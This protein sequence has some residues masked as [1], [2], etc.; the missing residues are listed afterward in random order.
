MPANDVVIEGTFNVNKY[1]I[2]W[3]NHDGSLIVGENLDYGTMPEYPGQDDPIKGAGDNEDGVYNFVGWTPDL[4]SV[5]G[6]AD[7]TATFTFTGWRSDANGKRYFVND[8]MQKGWLELDSGKYYLDPDTGYAAVGVVQIGED[9]PGHAFDANGVWQENVSGVF[10]DSRTED[11]YLIGSGIVEVFPGLYMTE[12]HEYYY[13][14][15]DNKAIRGEIKWVEKN[16]ADPDNVADRGMLPKWDYDF[17][18][19]GIIKH[20]DVSINGIHESDGV[21]YYYIDGIRVH[22]GMFMQDGYYY[23]ANRNGKLITDRTYWCTDNYGLMDEGSYPFDAQGRMIMPDTEKNGILEED[24]S[25][26]YYVD[27]V[28]T[29]AGLIE[30]DG[31]YYYVK[32]SGEVVH[33]QK[34]WIT[35]TNGV[36]QEKA[37][38]FDEHGR[39]VMPKNGILE[40]DGSLWY[41]VDGVRTYAGV[42]EYEGAYYYAK[43]NG[44]V[45]HGRSYWI[46]KTNGVVPEKSYVFENDGKMVL[47]VPIGGEG[48]NGIVDEAG[49]KWYYVDGK[50]TYA[51]L[52]LID[53]DYYYVKTNGEV[54]H[55][56]T[57]WITKTNGLLQEKAYTFDDS[58]KLVNP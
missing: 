21:L 12:N 42:F 57:Y 1:S 31:S 8:E 55:G 15:E 44:E 16:H 36:M 9:D 39:M 41:Y 34:Y 53:G 14:G 23:Y 43:T 51:G 33:G 19:D 46:T 13:F 37:Y 30:I 35:K 27:G 47:D 56:R 58:G 4:V 3:L 5:T 40:E 22:Y 24:G 7:Y 32:T 28:R 17:G 50:L 45:V 29:Y 20:E 18:D 48:K 11:V 54:V 6:D 10:T 26:W 25:L 49:S 52:I 2:R 38:T